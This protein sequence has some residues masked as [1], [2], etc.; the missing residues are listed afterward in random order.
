[1]TSNA[2]S[3]L[4]MKLCADPETRPEPQALAEALGPELRRIFKPALLGRLIVI[5]YYPI[6]DS[7]MRK[8]IE[9]KLKHI[10]KRLEENHR[11]KFSYSGELVTEVARRCTEVESGARNVDRILTGTLLPEVSTG[12]LSRMADGGRFEHV[13]VKIGNGGSFEYEID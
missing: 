11:V 4:L 13:H 8:I 3:D 5:P 1:M 10:Q 6:E 9:L 12:I 2:A 7:S